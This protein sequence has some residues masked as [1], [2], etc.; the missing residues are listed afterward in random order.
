[1]PD[2]IRDDT[3]LQLVDA[4]WVGEVERRRAAG[5]LPEELDFEGMPGEAEIQEGFDDFVACKG[6]RFRN[7]ADLA[8]HLE[9]WASLHG[10]ADH[11]EAKRLL[12]DVLALWRSSEP[13]PPARAKRRS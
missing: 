12:G 6:D 10:G 2:G 9:E 1:M 7:S 13:T 4:W 3:F 11:P 8:T 5:E